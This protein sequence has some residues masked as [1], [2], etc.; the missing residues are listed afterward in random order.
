M[1]KML[2]VE[3]EPIVRLALKSLIDWNNYGFDE[4]LEAS[5]GNKALEIIK[6]RGDIDIVITD[7][8]MPVMNGIEL[9]EESRRLGINTE[10]LVLSAYD[11][12]TLVRSAFKL[13]INDYILK[14]EME[15]DKILKMVMASLEDKKRKKGSKNQSVNRNELVRKLIAGDFTERDLENSV[16]RLKGENYICCSLLIDSFLIVKKRYEDN[17]L[18]ELMSS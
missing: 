5:N 7:I 11:D 4:V 10:F 6:A 13:G 14:T 3:D 2:L 12:Y 18:K 8:N 15:P 16:L 17:D 9:I 1:Y